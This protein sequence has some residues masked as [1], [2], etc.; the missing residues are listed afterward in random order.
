MRMVFVMHADMPRKRNLLIGAIDAKNW[1][2][3]V[4]NLEEMMVGMML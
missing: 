4:I 1:K 2:S 3:F